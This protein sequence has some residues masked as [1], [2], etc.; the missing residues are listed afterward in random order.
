MDS[1]KFSNVIVNAL[2]DLKARDIVRLDVRKLTTVTD[3]M[4]VA[5]GTSNRHVKAIADAVVEAARE[6][7][8][9]PTGIEGEEGSEWVLVD[10]GDTL[11]HVM[12]PR[13]REFYNLEKL[14]SLPASSAV[15]RDG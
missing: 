8:V 7:G 9:R 12:Q 10:L 4:I 11:V 2:E 6:A 15:A 14:W 1:E 5:S 3:Y 13:I